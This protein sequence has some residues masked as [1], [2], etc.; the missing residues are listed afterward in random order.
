MLTSSIRAKMGAAM[1]ADQLKGLKK[2]FDYSEYGGAPILGVRGSVIKIHGSSN[3]KAVANAIVKGVP[4]VEQDVVGIISRA[5][6]ELGD[7]EKSEEAA[8]EES[9]AADTGKEAE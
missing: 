9:G 2:V 4:Y 6:A 3:A 8:S 1:M 7:E 5:V